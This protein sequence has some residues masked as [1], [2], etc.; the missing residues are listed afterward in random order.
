VIGQH[1][2]G[3]SITQF[4]AFFRN[5]K[6]TGKWVFYMPISGFV[7]KHKLKVSANLKKM[8]CLRFF[9][10]HKTHYE[11]DLNSIYQTMSIIVKPSS[12]NGAFVIAAVDG[13]TFLK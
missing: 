2:S 11:L 5:P 12:S 9:V 10:M 1:F 4:F 13:T 3:H 8:K 7:L 6:V